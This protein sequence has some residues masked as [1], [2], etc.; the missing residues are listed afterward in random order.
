MDPAFYIT[1]NKTSVDWVAELETG[2]PTPLVSVIISLYNYENFIGNCLESVK[3]QSIGDLDL[4]IVDDCS[5]DASL[6]VAHEWIKANRARLNR[7]LLLKQRQNKGLA[8][9]RNIGFAQARTEYVFVLDADNEIYSYCLERLLAALS[10]CDASFAYCLHEKFGEEVG[11]LNTSPWNPTALSAGNTIDAMV[12]MRK[13]CWEEVGGYSLNMP[14]MGWEDY[15]LWFKVARC[16]GWGV[17]V[18][19]IL[20][21]YRFHRHSMLNTV[22][23]R[24]TDKLIDYLRQEYPE[25]FGLDGRKLTSA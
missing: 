13:R 12:L 5:K 21:R 18:P 6:D 16:G 20:A 19:E 25:F 2:R 8:Q 10:T 15:D 11:I 9:T 23:N 22:T 14:V 17:Q 7:V 24:N 4:I 1:V 3:A